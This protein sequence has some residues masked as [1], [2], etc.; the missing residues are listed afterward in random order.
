MGASES[1]GAAVHEDA[2]ETDMDALLER[3]LN[4]TTTIAVVGMKADPAEDAFRIPSY[5]AQHGYSI[6]PVNPKL[7][8]ALG[9]EA[10]PTLRAASEAGVAV[11]LVDVFRASENIEGH[12]D[13]ILSMQPRPTTVWLQL[14]I[15]HGP[16]AQRLRAAG[17][18][19]IQDRCIMVD[20]RRLSGRLERSPLQGA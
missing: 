6:V 18:D 5:M 3:V 20:H 16:S 4:R 14:G 10:F 1:N 19:V 15:H 11:D 12:V 2:S 17:I 13:D 7:E 9:R 8:R